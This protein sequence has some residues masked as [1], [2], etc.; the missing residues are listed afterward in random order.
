MHGF[1]SFD[2]GHLMMPSSTD[3]APD[4][5]LFIESDLFSGTSASA[6]VGGEAS[7]HL[8]ASGLKASTSPLS[9]SR[10]SSTP[11]SSSS[12]IFPPSPH[13]SDVFSFHSAGPSSALHDFTFDF[14]E[15]SQPS[16]DMHP[17]ITPFGQDPSKDAAFEEAARK[18]FSPKVEQDASLMWTDSDAMAED[19]SRAEAFESIGFDGPYAAAPSPAIANLDASSHAQVPQLPPPG[20]TVL[21]AQVAQAASSPTPPT[22]TAAEVQ[23]PRSEKKRKLNSTSA[24]DS[25]ASSGGKKGPRGRKA[26]AREQSKEAKEGADNAQADGPASPRAVEDRGTI[27]PDSTPTTQS[28]APKKAPGQRRPP[29][30]ASQITAAGNPFPVI[31]TSAKHSSLFVPPDTSGLTKREARL[32]KNRA[33]AFL[34]RQRK[35]EQFDELEVKCKALSRM[36]WRM[37][38]A[39]A[40]SDAP[41]EAIN[42]TILKVLFADEEAGVRSCL[43][44]IIRKKGA[45]IAPTAEDAHSTN[46]DSA[47]PESVRS[48]SPTKQGSPSPAPEET[49]ATP[50]KAKRGARAEVERLKAELSASKAREA[51][52]QREVESVRRTLRSTALCGEGERSWSATG[53]P[54]SIPP[55]ELP[56]PPHVPS[57][58]MQVPPNGLPTNGGGLSITI[59][60][61]PASLPAVGIKMERDDSLPVHFSSSADPV[62]TGDEMETSI[63]FARTPTIER[64][65]AAAI[66]SKKQSKAFA[67]GE[68]L[69]LGLNLGAIRM[70]SCSPTVQ[71]PSSP[72]TAST[73]SDSTTV[74]FGGGGGGGQSVVHH[75]AN[76]K[77]KAAGSMALMV[78]LFSFALLGM[79]AAEFSRIG[80]SRTGSSSLG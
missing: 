2:Q 33:A 71:P 28:A 10:S 7:S 9:L 44:E 24:A 66:R 80:L 30:S 45:S 6:P 34:S 16:I 51:S 73:T 48:S 62:R 19:T 37:W 79:P 52:L 77:R 15:N 13:L 78:I 46:R 36:G 27:D 29:P 8:Q 12:S 14:I 42:M 23:S 20:T 18:G 38:E 50:S 67:R 60:P 5:D 4:F 35:R 43:E 49:G 65:S 56:Q 70:A 39:I 64:F 47:A 55:C 26:G 11:Q 59:A 1:D 69:G 68:S 40:G 75:H 41:A 32:V 72:S 21:G 54:G 61:D 22:F 76:E 57:Q 58:H 74:H 63:D 3:Q 53:F 25:V 31:D 17:S